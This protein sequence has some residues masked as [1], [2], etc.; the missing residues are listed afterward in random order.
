MVGWHHQLNGHEFEQTL[1]D[2]DEQG[3]LVYCSPWGCKELDI[4]WRLN[5]SNKYPQENYLTLS[6]LYFLISIME[7][8][9]SPSQSYRE[10]AQGLINGHSLPSLVRSV[11]CE[12]SHLEEYKALFGGVSSGKGCCNVQARLGLSFGTFWLKSAQVLSPIR[13]APGFLLLCLRL[14]ECLSYRSRLWGRGQEAPTLASGLK[15]V[16]KSSFSSNKAPT[17]ICIQRLC[18]FLTLYTEFG[19]P[20]NDSIGLDSKR[21]RMVFLLLLFILN[22]HSCLLQCYMC[23]YRIYAARLSGLCFVVCKSQRTEIVSVNFSS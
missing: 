20:P 8:P 3:S 23:L 12:T 14:A 7:K 17:S 15:S 11:N 13:K 18:L 2:S 19:T 5:N 4:T 16:L 21:I 22:F 10:V 1:G 6:G 9:Q